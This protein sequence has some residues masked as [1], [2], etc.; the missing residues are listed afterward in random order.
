MSSFKF[1]T[2][3]EDFFDKMAAPKSMDV[4]IANGLEEAAAEIIQCDATITRHEFMKHMAI[5]RQKGM[6][7]WMEA[8]GQHN[9]V[10]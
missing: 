5:Y 4:V 9:R 2:K 3:V 1:W 10:P 7:T 6:I 8:N